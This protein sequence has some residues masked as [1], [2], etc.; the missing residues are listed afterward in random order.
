MREC[1]QSCKKKKETKRAANI[2]DFHKVQQAIRSPSILNVCD[3]HTHDLSFKALAGV[4][5]WAE[6]P[7]IITFMEDLE[8]SLQ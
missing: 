2:W 3:L 5:S 8:S 7:I 4:S 6:M 1:L